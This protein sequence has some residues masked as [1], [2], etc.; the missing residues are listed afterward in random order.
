MIADGICSQD[1]RDLIILEGP[2]NWFSYGQ[3]L[4]Y[5]KNCFNKFKKGCFSSKTV[6]LLIQV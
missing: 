3:I 1:L 5:I 2:E 6:L 4:M